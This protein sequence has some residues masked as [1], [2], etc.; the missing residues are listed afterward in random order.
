MV[1]KA[2]HEPGTFCWVELGTS[3]GPAAKKFY[4]SLFGW[5]V[6]EYPMG[7]GGTYTMLLKD[8]KEAGAL[9]ALGPEQKGV[10]PHW[11]S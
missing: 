11:N 2:K 5:T 10:P 8:G 7:E 3:D 1:E 6:N 4:T 9:Y